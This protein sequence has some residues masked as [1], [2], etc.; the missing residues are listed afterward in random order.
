MRDKEAK[1]RHVIAMLVENRTGV[2]ARI[3]GLIAAKGYNIESLSVG[4]T[5]D[6]TVSRMTL[7]VRGDDWVIEQAVK[8]LNR[9]IDVIKVS[10]L[11][12]EDIV[13]RELILMRV[14]AEPAIRAEVLRIA[15]IFRAK[16]VDVTPMTYTLELTGDEDKLD[17]F[18][19][20]LKPYGI[21]EFVR[22]GK[23]V[24]VRGSKAITKRYQ[25]KLKQVMDKEMTAGAQREEGNG[26]DLL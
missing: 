22:T 11:T 3:A 7:V 4:E 26:Q 17:A 12:D 18:I 21:Q 2:L 24:M 9:L 13:E 14:N 16:V 15:D 20:L 1:K 19:E 23:V 8:Q 5:L 25:E 10:D 6:Q